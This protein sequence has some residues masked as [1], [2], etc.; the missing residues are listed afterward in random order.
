MH[1]GNYIAN[2]MRNTFLFLFL[3]VAPGA[4]G[5]NNL[6]HLQKHS[7]QVMVFKTS[8]IKAEQYFAKDSI[9]LR[10]FETTIPTYILPAGSINFDTLPVG[11][12]VLASIVDN[13]VV[14]EVIG[15]SNL[16]VYPANNRYNIQLAIRNKDAAFVSDAKVWANGRAANYNKEA[17]TYRLPQ[18]K[19]EGAF[20]KVYTPGD[21]L[22]LDLKLDGEPPYPVL[23]Q[24]WRNFKA[25]RVGWLVTYIPVK[26]A[27]L[28][29]HRWYNRTKNREM[30]ICFLTSQNINLP[31]Q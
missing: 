22:L 10:E 30:V 9:P 17:N 21:T 6:Q 20:I 8:A 16:L 1:Q 5:Q 15:I 25:T 3:F 31:I 24:R 11:Y 19:L 27:L 28:F 4:M 26:T 13:Q 14:A 7:D 23:Q 2:R 18:R 29:K 12:F